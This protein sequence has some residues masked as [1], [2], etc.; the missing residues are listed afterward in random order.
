MEVNHHRYIFRTI[1]NR[2]E[3]EDTTSNKCS[4]RPYDDPEFFPDWETFLKGEVEI[5][6]TE[7]RHVSPISTPFT[8]NPLHDLE[9][10]WWIG[11]HFLVNKLPAVTPEHPHDDERVSEQRILASELFWTGRN[12]RTALEHPSYLMEQL[13]HLHPSVRPFWRILDDA[14]RHLLAGYW[15]AE[16]A[17]QTMNFD[18]A[19]GV[20]P[21][22]VRCFYS[23]AA[24][25]RAR[26]IELR[27]LEDEELHA[28]SVGPPSSKRHPE[29]V[30]SVHEGKEGHST[31]NEN[32]V[33]LHAPETA[34]SQR[35]SAR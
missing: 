2:D 5:T 18:V 11:I 6:K 27:S 32:P 3:D 12:R 13:E 17:G 28:A 21:A 34:L 7:W 15:R 29:D 25:L 9:S 35:S 4:P 20:H 22:L 33:S 26:D 30:K 31:Q 19:N 14:R 8:Y 1:L 10:L 16:K 24:R 23:I